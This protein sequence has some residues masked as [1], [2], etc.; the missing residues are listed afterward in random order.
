MFIYFVPHC[1]EE[2]IFSCLYVYYTKL[3]GNCQVIP[4]NQTTQVVR[5]KKIAI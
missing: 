1:K 2:P 4:Y 5:Q 3:A